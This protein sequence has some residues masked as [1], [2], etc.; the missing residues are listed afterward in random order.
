MNLDGICDSIRELLQYSD[1]TCDCITTSEES[2]GEETSGE[3]YC[4]EGM[5]KLENREFV[6]L[7]QWLPKMNQ[8][9]ERL[10]EI[11]DRM[12]V[13]AS[14]SRRNLERRLALLDDDAR[15]R[16]LKR[17]LVGDDLS[18][19]NGA[20]V[21]PG[22]DGSVSSGEVD[23]ASNADLHDESGS[24]LISPRSESIQLGSLIQSLPVELLYDVILEAQKSDPHIH[25]TLSH[26]NQYFRNLVNTSP[27]FWSKIDFWYP[28][29]LTSLYLQ[30]SAEA[31]LDVTADRGL[32]LHQSKAI[33]T[34]EP[35]KAAAFYALLWPHRHRIR[36]LTVQAPDL[37][38]LERDV[39]NENQ[40]AALSE[41]PDHFLW[42]PMA[43]ALEY[44]DLGFTDWGWME[45]PGHPVVTKLREL[46]LSG[47]CP[48]WVLSLVPPSLKRLTLGIP[49][50]TLPTLK[51]M[52]SSTPALESLRF[53]D[54]FVVQTHSEVS[55]FVVELGSLKSLSITRSC[56]TTIR[57]LL[58]II[59]C[60]DLQDLRLH[61]TFEMTEGSTSPW[62]VYHPLSATRLELFHKLHRRVRQLDI[63]SCEAD[64]DFLQR[65][66]DSLP[67]LTHLRIA[68]AE[69]TDEHLEALVFKRAESERCPELI[70]LTVENEDKASSAVIRRIVQS[71]TDASIPL[72]TVTLRGFDSA[73]VFKE[74]IEL[75]LKLGVADLTVTVF[76]EDEAAEG[77]KDAEWSSSWS[78]DE[79][80]DDELAS[81]DEDVLGR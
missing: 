8:A 41:P 30:R 39:Q 61:F 74:D 59:A 79:E 67:G 75:I 21:C 16:I 81:G 69:L 58:Q 68:S 70:S 35:T 34:K 37:L 60:P 49:G 3:D 19:M 28:P 31:S 77:E 72:Q 56:P 5:L 20:S 7:E 29:S 14:L 65:T 26:V 23:P 48:S 24:P 25:L 4:P 22:G 64:P 11:R 38:S 32:Q 27:L 45:F 54:V 46:R 63:V 9:V 55:D 76:S 73:K 17:H 53:L 13:Q 1:D 15:Q 33:M 78:S 12:V 10:V 40:P 18:S 80:S 57:D 2:D 71:R 47:P 6:V 44:L 66:L 62:R 42:S 51:N 50:L 43:C 52:L 36:R